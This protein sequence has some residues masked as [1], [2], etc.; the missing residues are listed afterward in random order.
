MPPGETTISS[1]KLV[2][3]TGC[4]T[5]NPALLARLRLHCR[6]WKKLYKFCVMHIHKV[7]H[8][9]FAVTWKN[10]FASMLMVLVFSW[11]GVCLDLCRRL[12]LISFRSLNQ[13]VILNAWQGKELG[14]EICVW[15]NTN[16]L[17]G[18]A[19][20]SVQCLFSLD[21]C[22]FCC[23]MGFPQRQQAGHF[24]AHVCKRSA[25]ATAERA[26]VCSL[27]VKDDP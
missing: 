11:N 26:R 7:S 9:E 21:A 25:A 27:Q 16:R 2:R 10:I 4:S 17:Q 13:P 20:C 3:A 8:R 18:E 5:E 6:I 1:R 15:I 12:D 23:H 14:H 19:V 22:G 24:S